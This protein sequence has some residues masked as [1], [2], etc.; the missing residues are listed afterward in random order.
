MNFDQDRAKVALSTKTNNFPMGLHMP[1]LTFIIILAMAVALGPFAVDTYLPAFPGI[2]QSL[3]VSID[4]VGLS[5]SIY[6]FGLALG[7]LIGGFLSDRYGRARLMIT[8][9]AIFSISSFLL[10]FSHTLEQ[11]LFLRLL[12]ALGGGCCGVNVPAIVRDRTQGREAAKLF[13]LISSIYIIAPAIAPGIGSLILAISNWSGIFIFLALYALLLMILLKSYVFSSSTHASSRD[14]SLKKLSIIAG[15]SL[16]LKNKAARY[17]ILLQAFSFSVMLIFLTNASFIYQQWFGVTTFAFSMLF[18]CNIAM[19]GFLSFINRW[20]V[21]RLEP[22]IK[23][24]QCQTSIL[25]RIQQLERSER[26]NYALVRIGGLIIF[27]GALV[28]YWFKA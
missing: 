8:G 21:H 12:Q 11:L 2:A 14:S 9:L 20:L 24:F 13:S 6:I 4:K 27:N 5:I 15:F 3:Q 28:E 16:V 19:M 17:L 1:S 23:F 22:M 25:S 26:N 7:Q 18:A 10:A